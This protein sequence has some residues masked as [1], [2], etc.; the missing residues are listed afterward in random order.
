MPRSRGDVETRGEVHARKVDPEALERARG[1]VSTLGAKVWATA[2]Y[3]DERCAVRLHIAVPYEAPEGERTA[4]YGMDLTA[5]DG[6]AFE[7][8]FQE[9]IEANLPELLRLGRRAAA[10][11]MLAADRDGEG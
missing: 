10:E 3:E 5:E 4:G 7:T 1:R 2:R 9:L 11:S 6:S 8:A